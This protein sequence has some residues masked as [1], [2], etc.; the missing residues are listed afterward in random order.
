MPTCLFEKEY[1]GFHELQRDRRSAKLPHED[2]V[3]IL[4]KGLKYYN[5]NIYYHH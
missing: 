4:F 2:P 5:E 1:L 3:L